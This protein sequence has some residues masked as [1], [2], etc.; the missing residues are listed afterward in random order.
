M[1]SG[2]GSIHGPHG[3]LFFAAQ[4]D[5]VQ[6]VTESAELLGLRVTFLAAAHPEHGHK[7]AG[8]V[9]QTPVIGNQEMTVTVE[10]HIEPTEA[11]RDQ[12]AP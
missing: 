8:S 12:P 2:S 3:D 9:T 1:I 7:M 10:W 6:A 4:S 11:P 5:L